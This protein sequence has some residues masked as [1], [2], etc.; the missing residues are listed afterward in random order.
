MKHLL[1]ACLF[2]VCVLGCKESSSSPSMS[3]EV[4]RAI[5]DDVSRR[6][7]AYEPLTEHDDR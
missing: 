1:L 2:A 4:A 5:M 7:L 3:R 6:N